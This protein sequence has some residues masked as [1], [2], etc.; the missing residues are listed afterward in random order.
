MGIDRKARVLARKA[1]FLLR[2]AELLT[3]EV[4]QVRRVAAVEHRERRLES[5]DL[6]V[7][8]QQ[9]IADRMVGAGPEQAAAMAVHIH[10]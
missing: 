4:E 8:A 2:Q 3:Q 7:F 10:I 6:R 5:D 9:P 1:L